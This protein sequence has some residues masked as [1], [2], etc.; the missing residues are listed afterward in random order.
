MITI[1]ISNCN[2]YLGHRIDLDQ[3]GV[4]RALEPGD[5]TGPANGSASGID[6]LLHTLEA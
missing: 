2:V 1:R 4:S 6:Q 5:A 3:M